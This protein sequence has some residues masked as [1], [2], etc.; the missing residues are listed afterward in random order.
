MEGQ[1]ALNMYGQ[2][3]LGAVTAHL[4][5]QVTCLFLECRL[6]FRVN[7]TIIKYLNL[8]TKQVTTLYEGLKEPGWCYTVNGTPQQP[9]QPRD[10]YVVV[11]NNIL[12]VQPGC[13]PKKQV[14]LQWPDGFMSDTSKYVRLAVVVRWRGRVGCHVRPASSVMWA[15]V[16]CGT[17]NRACASAGRATY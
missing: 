5:N 11:D 4:A 9:G 14:P 16:S 3:K 17:H 6:S 15:Y 1:Q 10:I 12:L 8:G 7:E 13:P 2:G